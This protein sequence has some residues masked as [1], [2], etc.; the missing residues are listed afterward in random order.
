MNID[1]ELTQDDLEIAETIARSPDCLLATTLKEWS[2][3]PRNL[4]IA[5]EAVIF[6]QDMGR[7]AEVLHNFLASHDGMVW[8]DDEEGGAR[9]IA[10]NDRKRRG[11]RDR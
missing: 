10:R 6:R 9:R 1:H 7:P 2:G 11:K 4:A 5:R 3:N 8:V